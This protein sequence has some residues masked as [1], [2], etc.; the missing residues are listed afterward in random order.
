MSGSV[1]SS[2]SYLG[3]SHQIAVLRGSVSGPE[4]LVDERPRSGAAVQHD[5]SHDFRPAY[6]LQVC[7]EETVRPRY[8]LFTA[9]KPRGLTHTGWAEKKRSNFEVVLL[10]NYTTEKLQIWMV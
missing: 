9:R 4:E 8:M 10:I 7:S 2:C 1:P 3:E 5:S 6:D